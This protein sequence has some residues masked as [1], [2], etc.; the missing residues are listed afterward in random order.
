MKEDILVLAELMLCAERFCIAVENSM[1]SFPKAEKD[2]LKLKLSQC[3]GFL[4]SL[5]DR[6][7]EDE[8]KM[9][10]ASV[11]MDLRHLV[12]ALLWVAFAARQVI[13]RKTFRMV[14][15]IEFSVS[16]LLDKTFAQTSGPDGSSIGTL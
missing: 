4:S 13:D 7:D 8:L 5:Q 1:A 15:M 16:H 3:R 2:E 14:V 10:T 6:F 11:R 12:L 9:E